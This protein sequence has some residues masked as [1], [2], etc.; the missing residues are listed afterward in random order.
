V[1][2]LAAVLYGS[3][4]GGIAGFI[5]VVVST[6]TAALLGISKDSIAQGLYGFNGVLVGIAL[7]LFLEY[8]PLLIIYIVFGSIISTIITAAFASLFGRLDVPTLTGP[9]VLTTWLMLFGVYLI[10]GLS[11]AGLN[12]GILANTAADP[13]TGH[14]ILYG[15]FNNIA[16][17]M[18][19][20]KI[21]SGIL[22]LIGLLINSPYSALLAA[23]GSIASLGA[24]AV[25]GGL[26]STATSGLYG[27]NAVLCAIGL[28]TI[29]IKPSVKAFIYAVIASFASVIVFLAIGVLITPYGMP[30]LTSPFV[31]TTWLFLWG[32]QKFNVKAE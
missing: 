19:Q 21:V 3:I 12:P 17:V 27:F 5:G 14:G 22:F 23:V 31:L 13:I 10:S 28:G 2:F 18:F 8:S 9:F 1:F 25:L 30:G 7:S 16:E 20:A 24:A 4:W 32:W 29:F 6:V 15:F 11:Y 26:D